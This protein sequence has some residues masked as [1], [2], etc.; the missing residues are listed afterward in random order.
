MRN[1]ILSLG[2]VLLFQSCK[3]VDAYNASVTE[4]KSVKELR[5][6]VDV[7]YYKLK[8][9]HPHLY[10]YTTK[11]SLD[12][13]FENLKSNITEPLTPEEFHKKLTPVVTQVGQGHLSTTRPYKKLSKAKRKSLKGKR[14]EFYALGYEY[15][16]EG[17]FV[18]GTN[19]YD[20]LLVGSRI[21]K[22]NDEPVG[23]LFE[24]FKKSIS[25]D[26]YNA[27]F[28]NRFVSQHFDR[29]YIKDKGFQDSIRVT[30]QKKDSVYSRVFRYVK[31]DSVYYPSE[32]KP[33]DSVAPRKLT[34]AEK[35]LQKEKAKQKR[36]YNKIHGFNPSD[37]NYTRNFELIGKDSAVAYMKIRGFNSGKYKPFYEKSFDSIKAENI[38]NLVLDLRDNNGGSL[39]EISV[40]YSYLVQE[41]FTFINQAEVNSRIPTLKALIS[42]GNPTAFNVVGSIL[43]PIFALRDLINTHK[44]K[45]KLYYKFKQSKIMKPSEN[46]FSGKVYVLINGSS[47]SASSILS[48]NLQATGRATFVGEETGGAYNGTVAGSYK[49]VKLPASQVKLR[50]GLL[51]IEA[52]YKQEPDG[53]GIKPDVGIVPT[54][55]ALNKSEDEALQW[56][57]ND[58]Q[59][60]N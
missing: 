49:I 2:I 19:N 24:K 14:F 58:I 42:K 39:K 43:S 22:V 1:F 55:E 57:L 13:A 18:K 38:E 53:Y 56:I 9:L 31:N 30:F 41:P 34:R 20:S 11:D 6:D 37:N 26:G 32:K 44:E 54:L 15:V 51:Q 3:S 59:G 28:Y 5:N 47:F 29:L 52:P 45:G 8:K 4:K 16:D 33:N 23:K 7:A 60:S 35:K 36:R 27:T 21:V 40:L 50:V 46:N 12:S 48:T 25:S 10:Q 17:L